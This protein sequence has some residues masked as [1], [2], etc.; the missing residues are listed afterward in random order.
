MN[1]KANNVLG[2]LEGTFEDLQRILVPIFICWGIGFYCLVTFM[3]MLLNPNLKIFRSLSFK[4][5]F[6]YS[7]IEEILIPE[8]HVTLPIQKNFPIIKKYRITLLENMSYAV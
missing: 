4:D 7:Y 6:V 5:T 3:I 1:I 8:G 2:N